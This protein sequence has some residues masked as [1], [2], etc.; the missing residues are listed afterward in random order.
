VRTG[1][2]IVAAAWSAASSGAGNADA[3]TSPG[4]QAAYSAQQS[5]TADRCLIGKAPVSER[6]LDEVRRSAQ[7]LMNDYW[8]RA[9]ASRADGIVNWADG[10]ARLTQSEMKRVIDPFARN[11]DFRLAPIASSFARSLAGRDF[12]RGVWPVYIRT[13]PGAVAGYYVVDFKRS[14]LNWQISRFELMRAAAEAPLASQSCARSADRE[15]AV[16]SSADDAPAMPAAAVQTQA[17]DSGWITRRY[18]K[19][20]TE[21][22]APAEVAPDSEDSPNAVAGS[23]TQARLAQASAPAQVSSP[24]PTPPLSSESPVAQAAGVP[25][26][27]AAARDGNGTAPLPHTLSEPDAPQYK[28][29]TGDKIRINTFGED[30][31]SGEFLVH[32]DGKITFPLF[33]DIPAAGLTPPQLASAISSRMA[34]DYLR[35][36]RVTAEVIAFRPVY[37]LGEVARP[38]EYQYA[39]GMTM[40]AL[41][42]QAGGFSYRANHKRAFVRHE[43][44]TAEQRLDIQ[45]ATPVLPGDTIRIP[46]RIF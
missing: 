16:A 23:S 41:I 34:P 25:G 6:N 4:R 31:F 22:D 3:W 14:L 37:I 18:G 8:A 21:H 27:P 46:Q 24:P 33:G 28:I 11:P 15:T 17:D 12:A 7:A 43:G 40:F 10:S 30:R 36:P 32:R 35:D 9:A 1:L 20:T 5:G 2:F 45:S 19:W 42:A 26:R 38:G 29:A 39:E 13:D 44:E